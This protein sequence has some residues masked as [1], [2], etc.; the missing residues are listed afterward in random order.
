MYIELHAA[1]AFSFL[2]GVS[3]P[4]QLAEQAAKLSLPAMAVLDRDGVF[5]APRFYAAANE[6][7]IRPLV[8]AEVTLAD[9]SVLPLLVRNRTGYQNLCQL[10]TDAKLRPRPAGLA[11]EGLAPA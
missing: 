6:Q 1:R 10:I 11:P 4:E 5:G 8:G 9:G 2:R 3:L 7:K